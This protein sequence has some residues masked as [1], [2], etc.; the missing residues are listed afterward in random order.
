MGYE[1][2][3]VEVEVAILIAVE[4]A[5]VQEVGKELAPAPEGSPAVEKVTA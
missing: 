1:P 4:Q 3:A 2:A 5:G